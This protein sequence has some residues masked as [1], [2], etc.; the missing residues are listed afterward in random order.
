MP[1]G[2]TWG[3]YSRF[4]VAALLSMFAGSQTVHYLF[5]PL[6]DFNALV[7]AEKQ[8]ILEE[9]GKLQEQEK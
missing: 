4:M 8:K 3:V 9:Q 1:A 2:V 6:D 5:H 7:E